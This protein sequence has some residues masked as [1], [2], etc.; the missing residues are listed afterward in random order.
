MK[1][2]H[3]L[4]AY[5]IEDNSKR[6]KLHKLIKRFGDPVQYSLFE[7]LITKE[8]FEKMKLLIAKIPLE[9]ADSVCY[10]ELCQACS[11]QVSRTG[12]AKDFLKEEI[13]V[14]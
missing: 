14:F 4:V 11:K 3:I 13:F 1:L 6:T 7:C 9:R 2:I 12:K 8:Q 5:D 10:Y